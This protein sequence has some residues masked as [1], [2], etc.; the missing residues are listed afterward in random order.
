MMLMMAMSVTH[1]ASAQ[2]TSRHFHHTVRTSAPPQR[3]WALWMDVPGWPAWDTELSAAS[4]DAPLALGVQGTVTSGSRT[5]PF[6]VTV[7]EP[8]RHYAY[9]VPLPLGKLVVDRSLQPW[10][11]GGT[12]FTHEVRLTGLGGLVL[13]GLGKQFRAAL[14]GVMDAL[15]ALAEAE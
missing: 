6:T 10:G 7:F 9:T 3:V 1:A 5:S 13:A 12:A 8:G 15:A 4:Q 11:D 2:G 14:P